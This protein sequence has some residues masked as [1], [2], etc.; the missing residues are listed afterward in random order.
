[1]KKANKTEAV[2]GYP[3][4]YDWRAEDD[5]RTLARAVEIRNDPKRFAAARKCAKKKMAE[6]Q[7]VIGSK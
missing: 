1:M 2:A 5:M 4:E 6:M 3:G 7:K